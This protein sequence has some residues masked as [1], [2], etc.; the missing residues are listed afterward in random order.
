M[1][2]SLQNTFKH[3][4]ATM[5]NFHLNQV[6]VMGSNTSPK[7]MKMKNENKSVV[8]PE[9]RW[10]VGREEKGDEKMKKEIYL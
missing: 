6:A 9:S 8:W 4:T 10:N 3:W 7:N 5:L 1:K 2:T